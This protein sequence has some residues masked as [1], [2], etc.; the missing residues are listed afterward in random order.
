MRMKLSIV[1]PA[2]NEEKRLAACIRS[3]KAALAACGLDPETVELIVCDNNSTDATPRIA[4]QEGAKSV[5][6]PHN[7]ISRARNAGA[8]EATGD[9]F[10]FIDADSLLH[11]ETLREALDAMENG[12]LAG[13]GCVIA[14]D[15]I[16]L[17]WRPV[18]TAW[19][20]ISRT[21]LWAAG[22]F[23][24]CRADAF[25]ETGGFPEELYAGEEIR[26]SQALKAWGRTRGLGFAI[27]SRR[28]HLSSG[29]KAHLYGPAEFLSMLRVA[30]RSPS[31][32]LR[33][34]DG[35]DIFYDGRR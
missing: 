16:P 3:A 15:D 29:R 28:A 35:L 26:L 19:N 17:H 14:F 9:W 34:R 13:G 5:F 10:L 12:R 11:P 6:E 30:L 18:V 27:L 24:F 4:R 8:R 23:V 7:Q 20:L 21:L 32:A 22:S 1:I 25:R 31:K 33:S 2:F